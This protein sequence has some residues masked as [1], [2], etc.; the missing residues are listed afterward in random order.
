MDPHAWADDSVGSWVSDHG[1]QVAKHLYVPLPP[2]PPPHPPQGQGHRQE[3]GGPRLELPQGFD[4]HFR[5]CRTF[6]APTI[7]NRSCFSKCK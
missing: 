3:G 4:E 5:L 6:L 7:G 2:L 1:Q